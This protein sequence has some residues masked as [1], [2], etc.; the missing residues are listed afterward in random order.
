MRPISIVI[1]VDTLAHTHARALTPGPLICRYPQSGALPSASTKT[2]VQ[3]EGGHRERHAEENT[4]QFND[5]DCSKK[6]RKQQ[7]NRKRDNKD[8]TRSYAQVDCAS[9][10]T[11]SQSASQLGTSLSNKPKKEKKNRKERPVLSLSDW[12]AAGGKIKKSKACVANGESVNEQEGRFPYSS[13]VKCV[14]GAC[15]AVRAA[16]YVAQQN[17]L[18]A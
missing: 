14:A 18:H 1:C 3:C 4:S 12:L 16:L 5:A 11:V 7:K 17:A 9:D 15:G 8:E 6:K 2:N 10:G 13:I